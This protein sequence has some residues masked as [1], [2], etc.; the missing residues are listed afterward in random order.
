[1]SKPP[2]QLQST[3]APHAAP[4]VKSPVRLGGARPWL[5]SSPQ[6]GFNEGWVMELG[7]LVF[8]A[9]IGAVAVGLGGCKAKDSA[10]CTLDPQKRAHLPLDAGCKGGCPG[11][12]TLA[13]AELCGKGFG[14]VTLTKGCGALDVKTTDGFVGSGYAFDAAGKKLRGKLSHSDIPSGECNVFGY[15]YGVGFD[16]C[17]TPTMSCNPCAPAGDPAGCP[18]L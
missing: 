16:T 11:T 14:R 18:S 8:I 2:T 4:V 3:R 7:R 10:R 9:A 1:M 12:A 17:S 13:I 15:V 5:E 6:L